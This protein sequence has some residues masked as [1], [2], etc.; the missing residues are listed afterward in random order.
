MPKCKFNLQKNGFIHKWSD[1]KHIISIINDHE[2]SYIDYI[3]NAIQALELCE[4][5]NECST[6]QFIKDQL[7]LLLK[8]PKRRIYSKHTVIFS[9]ELLGVS[10]AAF[11]LVRNS[12]SLILPNEGLIRSLISNTFK[13]E[14][15]GNILK[16]LN[17]QQRVVNMLF[18]EV[19]LKKS[20]RYYGNHLLGY[21]ENNPSDLATS[22]LVI[23]LVCHY[24]GPKYIFRIYPVNKLNAQQLRP[25]LLEA[26]NTV[27]Q[28]GGHLLSLICDNCTLN[29]ATYKAL[30]GPG[31]VDL[32]PIGISIFLLY[33]YVHIFKN[34]RNNWYTEPSKK[35]T[36][37]VDNKDYLASWN[38]IETLYNADKVMPVRLTKLTQASVYPKPLQRQSVPLVCKVFNEKT[39]AALLSLNN[40]FQFQEGTII[41]INLVSQWFK[42][43]NIKDKYA[44]IRLKDDLRAPWV[45]NCPS[46]GKLKEMCKVI[47]SCRWSG[48]RGRVQKMTQF[49]ADAF[50]VTTTNVISAAEYLL[51]DLNFQ[52]VLPAVFS[53]DPEEKFFGQARQR[54]GGKFYIDITDVVAAGRTQQMHQLIKY[55]AAP[56][57]SDRKGINCP[58]CSQEILSEDIDLVHELDIHETQS[59]M[60]TS[61]IL[62][63]KVVYLGGFLNHKYIEVNAEEEEIS[64]EF[65][66]ELNCGGLH[67]PTLNT[68]YF[69]Y[70]AINLH[71]KLDL[72]RKKCN[73]YF[74]KLLTFI[75]VPLALNDKACNSLTNILFKAFSLNVSD[76]EKQKGCLRR[77]EKLSD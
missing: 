1:V 43:M 16:N 6:L 32:Q 7:K 57:C 50:I 4:E 30:G 70:C 15:L 42:M 46:F 23:E 5:F 77:A 39:S 29:Q 31:K 18:D 44:C 22:A 13:D 74:K 35:L 28:K 71:N 54:S 68:V 24:G 38:D 20:I 3:N 65:I 8:P 14:N 34:I 11:R 40:Q 41:F 62:K 37:T 61:D 27:V 33:D 67:L 72:P 9:L 69:V 59:L 36:F 19:K 75:D 51:K 17:P 47:S 2:N 52:Y 25:M 10:P 26:A 56:D 73:K 64:S 12:K 45:L 76:N 48:G 21:S 63:Q 49:T 53:Q 58:V 60:E 66:S 55:D